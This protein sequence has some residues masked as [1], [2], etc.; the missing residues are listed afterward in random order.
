MWL[1]GP[2]GTW[3]HDLP[4]VKQLKAEAELQ[5]SGSSPHNLVENV[6]TVLEYGTFLNWYRIVHWY[7][8]EIRPHL[9]SHPD[10][11]KEWGRGGWILFFIF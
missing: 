1:Y 7:K 2:S 6:I 3:S 5:H 11:E 10:L 8:A 4:I 9:D